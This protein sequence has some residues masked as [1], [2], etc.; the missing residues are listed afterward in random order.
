MR[1]KL[2][3]FSLEGKTILVTGA[4]S[5]IGKATAIECSRMGAKV[6]LLARNEDRLRETMSLLPNPTKVNEYKVIDLTDNDALKAFVKEMSNIDGLFLSAGK[7]VTKPIKFSGREAFDDIFEINFFAQVELMRELIKKKKLNKGASIVAVAS[8]AA[9]NGIAPGSA[10]YGASKGALNTFMKYAAVELAP[11]LIRVN[12][13]CPG[14][15]ETPLIHRGTVSDDQMN[16]VVA[17][18]PLKRFG[19]PED[20]AYSAVFL[21]SDAS[22]WITGTSMAIDGGCTLSTV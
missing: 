11:N 9:T 10:I 3:P 13:L 2:N 18:Y 8:I 17:N 4:S 22:S 16:E 7:G 6:I 20:I 21:L 5:G 15:V 14:L 19:K 1:D 12:T